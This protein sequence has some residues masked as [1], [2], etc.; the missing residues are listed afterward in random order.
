MRGADRGA[1]C[2]PPSCPSVRL[3][4]PAPGVCVNTHRHCQ[5]KVAAIAITSHTRVKY[6]LPRQARCQPQ[7]IPP[8]YCFNTQVLQQETNHNVP[9]TASS[10]FTEDGRRV[11][12]DL[13]A[14]TGSVVWEGGDFCVCRGKTARETVSK[15]V[16]TS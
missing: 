9:P 5:L 14:V 6:G 4:P 12:D 10:P 16:R 2:P 15:L 13:Q 1:P 7:S 8:F 11:F 3:Y